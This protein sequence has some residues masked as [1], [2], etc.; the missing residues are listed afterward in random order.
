MLLDLTVEDPIQGDSEVPV[1]GPTVGPGEC[2]LTCPHNAMENG[3][4]LM[5]QPC[6]YVVRIQE[7]F[8]GDYSVSSCIIFL[9]CG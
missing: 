8:K 4:E 7:V 9:R 5:S 3:H 6:V 1:D 2:R